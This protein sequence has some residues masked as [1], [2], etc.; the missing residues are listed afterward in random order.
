MTVTLAASSLVQDIEVQS[1]G[2]GLW[3]A[4]RI[5]SQHWKT[6]PRVKMD[7]WDNR[8]Q[9]GVPAVTAVMKKKSAACRG[10]DGG[11]AQSVNESIDSACCQTGGCEMRGPRMRVPFEAQAVP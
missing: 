11:I 2:A 10:C 7:P 3:H 6:V 1:C 9:R 4:G 5:E 8:Q